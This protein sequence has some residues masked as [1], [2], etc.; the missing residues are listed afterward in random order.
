MYGALEIKVESGSM[1]I[2]VLLEEYEHFVHVAD[3]MIARYSGGATP[4]GGELISD[5]F[6]N[7][8][9][10]IDERMVPSCRED[11][12]KIIVSNIS[13]YSRNRRY[14]AGDLDCDSLYNREGEAIDIADRATEEQYEEVQKVEAAVE[15]FSDTFEEEADKVNDT[16]ERLSKLADKINDIESDPEIDDCTKRRKVDALLTGVRAVGFKT[17][18]TEDFKECFRVLLMNARNGVASI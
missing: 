15:F 18:H 8:Q 11:A 2:E 7:L 16:V 14:R 12:R 9:N 10:H 13:K 5:L 1:L 4:M 17:D 6:V 3:G